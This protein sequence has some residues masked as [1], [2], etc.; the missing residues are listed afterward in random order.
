ML[1]QK[2][3]EGK[4]KILYKNSKNAGEIYQYFKDDATA[5]NNQ[6]KSIIESKG[7]LNNFISEYIMIELSKN[8]IENHFIKRI[9]SRVQLVKKL[10]IIPLEVIVRN[11]SA[12]S[13]SKRLNVA[14]GTKLNKVVI[15][16]C[17]KDD[18]LGDP[19]INDDHIEALN[20]ANKSEIEFI[21]NVTLNVNKILNNIFSSINIKLV[22]FKI[23]FG[24]NSAGNIILA[25]EI[26]PDS[27]RLWD[28]NTGENMDKDRF[29]LDLGDL[30]KYYKIIA[31]R[32]NLT[33]DEVNNV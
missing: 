20:I 22:D 2:I 21:K 31:D 29:R 12:G 15:E 9:D 11:Y 10:T 13:F 1:G 14:M 8:S 28:I 19:L 27:C 23:E 4:A 16:F 18:A 17:L 32:L 24:K 7:V 26:S 3:Y 5:F 33:I 30:T 25:D 6:K